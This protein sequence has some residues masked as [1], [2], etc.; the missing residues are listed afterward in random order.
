MA[1]SPWTEVT[2]LY[3][4]SCMAPAAGAAQNPSVL[5]FLV[6]F[7]S[8]K[9]ESCI[10]ALCLKAISAPDSESAKQVSEELRAA[11]QEHLESARGSLTDQMAVLKKRSFHA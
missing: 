9:T 10:R 6:Y 11:I 2:F 1:F 8:E 3:R 5:N 4:L 7:M